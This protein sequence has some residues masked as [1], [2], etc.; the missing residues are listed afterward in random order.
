MQLRKGRTK[1]ILIGSLDSALLAVEIYNKP[2][3][4]FR[5]EG[6]ISLII[7]AWTKLFHAYFNYHIDNRYYYKKDNGRYE[8]VDGERKAWELKTCIKEYNKIA[9]DHLDESLIANLKFFIGLRNKIAHRHV[10]KS[11]IDTL[12]FGECQSLLFNYETLVIEIFGKEYA[13]NEN[14][15]YSLQFSKMRKQEQI[16][17]NKKALSREV[18]DIKNYVDKYR[19]Q[20]SD[21]TFKSQNYSIKLIQIPKISNTNR[22]DLAVEFVRWD[23]LSEE[24]REAY[25]RVTTIIKDKVI[26]Q[27]AANV[28]KNRPSDVLDKVEEE[29]DVELN[30]YYHKCF[31]YVFSVR[32]LGSDENADPFDTNTKYCHYDEVHDDHVYTED[33]VSFLIE[34]FKKK[35]MPKEE[36]KDCFQNEKKINIKKFE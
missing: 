3:T 2:R 22:S 9:D 18:R 21:E 4:T 30:H 15:V 19:T 32:P 33:W 17:A 36:I 11:E 13:L 8:R 24:D 35:K 6:F 12:I 31:Y 16:E 20:L 27:E 23:E 34:F 14:L 29:I 5:T 10:D 26:K 1:S 28:G 25:E 7:I